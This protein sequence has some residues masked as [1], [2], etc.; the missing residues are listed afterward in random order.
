MNNKEADQL[1]LMNRIFNRFK[2]LEKEFFQKLN[3][4]HFEGT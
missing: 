4:Q 3:T 2:D 1:I